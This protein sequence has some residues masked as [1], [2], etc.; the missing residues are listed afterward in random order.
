VFVPRPEPLPILLCD[1]VHLDPATKRKTLLGLYPHVV[2]ESFPHAMPPVWLY[3]GFTGA[4]GTLTL[5]VRVHDGSKM[6]FEAGAQL[7]GGDPDST[8]ELT[9]PLRGL[10]F[11]A[12]GVYVI[13]A[14]AGG[15]VFAARELRVTARAAAGV[16]PLALA[17][18]AT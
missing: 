13:E 1:H 6:L 14:L 12:P 18:S 5:S 9:V 11:P 15:V 17:T 7:Q 8:Y 3:V 16:R 10:K 4:W 2:A